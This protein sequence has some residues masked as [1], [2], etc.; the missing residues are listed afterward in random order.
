VSLREY[1]AALRRRWVVIVAVC[2]V[3]VGATAVFTIRQTPQYSAGAQ[4]FVSSGGG[5][6]TISQAYQGGL[7]VQQRI[8]SYLQLATSPEVLEPAA[9]ELGSSA[10][11][12]SLASRVSADS[13]VDTVL[14]TISATSEDPDQAADIANTVALNFADYVESLE[15]REGQQTAPVKISLTHPATPPGAPVSPQP[16]VNLLLGL[17][18]G[19]ALGLGVASVRELLDTAL[20]SEDEIAETA[21]VPVLGRVAADKDTTKTPIA[22]LSGRSAR[23]EAFRVLRTNLQYVDA[24]QATR[25]VVVTSSVASEGKTTTAANLAAAMAR[26]GLRVILVEC[27]LRRPRSIEMIGLVGGVGLT[28]V[29]VGR[30]SHDEVVQ[31]VDHVGIDVLGSGPTPPNPSE[32]LASPA[33]S[34]LLRDLSATYD[35]VILDAPPLVPVTD[36][37]VLARAADGALVVVRHG[38]TTREQLSAAR[39]ALAAVDA[40]VLGV[41]INMLPPRGSAYGYGYYGQRETS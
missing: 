31:R 23:A 18:V 20:H 25:T 32:L 22:E 33:M 14:I 37:A 5:E 2:L 7:F 29:L 41:V 4:L 8:R 34:R 3:T 11:Q 24:E 38:T 13:P 28:D 9:E 19:L 6:D 39:D 40:R 26:T 10:S 35:R 16:V 30:A 36:A 27:D 21:G 12:A 15:S 1:L 17:A